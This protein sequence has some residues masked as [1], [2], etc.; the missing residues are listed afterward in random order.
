MG[1]RRKTRKLLVRSKRRLPTV[2][3]CPYCGSVAVNVSV[4]KKENKVKVVCG[5]CGLEA[6]FDRINGLLPVDY[7]N[8]FVDKYFAGELKPARQAEVRAS[9]V[10]NQQNQGIIDSDEGIEYL[11]AP[12]P[13]ADVE[14]E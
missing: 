4:S 9:A 3:Q 7:Y 11:D 14:E 10:N 1:K 5:V 6:E 13:D 12:E 2:F 8:K